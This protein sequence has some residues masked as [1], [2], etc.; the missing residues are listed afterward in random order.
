MQ[1]LSVTTLMVVSTVTAS[2]DFL[3]MD[4]NVQVLTTT[5]QYCV[6]LRYSVAYIAN[7]LP[8]RH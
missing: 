3:G 5:N 4:S 8:C 6:T 7:S 1:M 2:Q